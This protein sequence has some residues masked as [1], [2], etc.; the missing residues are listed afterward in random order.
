MQEAFAMLLAPPLSKLL[1]VKRLCE[2]LE[3]L[4]MPEAQHGR[5]E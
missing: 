5:A 2:Q 4:F 3:S 1:T